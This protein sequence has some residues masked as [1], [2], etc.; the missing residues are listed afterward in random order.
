[1]P[2]VACFPTLYT[3]NPTL[4]WR[5]TAELTMTIDPC[6]CCDMGGITARLRWNAD[7]KFPSRLCSNT[8]VA[9]SAIGASGGMT[10]A[11]LINPSTAS[12]ACQRHVN[13]PV[14]VCWVARICWHRQRISASEQ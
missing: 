9:T 8:S 5:T 11:L 10:A 1:M 12:E 6:P 13:D 3:P 4:G 7:R 14:R 2:T